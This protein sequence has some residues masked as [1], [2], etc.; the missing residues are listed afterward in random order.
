[1][2]S[3]IPKSRAMHAAPFFSR[4]YAGFSIAQAKFISEIVPDRRGLRIVDPMC[5]Q[6]LLAATWAH[7]GATVFCADINPGPLALAALRSPL[8]I[9]GRARQSEQLRGLLYDRCIGQPTDPP[10]ESLDEAGESEDWLIPRVRNELRSLGIALGLNTQSDLARAF[11]MRDPFR[12]FAIGICALA[13]RQ[14][15]TFR[16]SDNVTWLRPGGLAA[17]TRLSEVLNSTIDEWVQWATQTHV[18]RPTGSLALQLSSIS[19]YRP[20]ETADLLVTSPPYANR[21]DYKRMWAPETAVVQALIDGSLSTIGP[22]IGSNQTRQPHDAELRRLPRSVRSALSKIR[23]HEAWGSSWYYYPF[24]A[25]YAVDL[26]SA[27]RQMSMLLRRKGTAIVFG[28]DTVRK[29]TL[30]PTIDVVSHAMRSSGFDVSIREHRIIRSHLGNMRT[31]TEVGL[32]GKAQREWWMVLR[33][34]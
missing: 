32:Y 28:R 2:R 30:F 4:A 26:D 15:A 33:K 12:R 5:G 21:L 13:A 17:P 25:S 22:F 11:S 3:I 34:R 20:A 10:L 8:L 7:E 27:C 14:L 23:S 9:A 31:S 1:M 6:A 18:A 29:D 24:F 16:L 19:R